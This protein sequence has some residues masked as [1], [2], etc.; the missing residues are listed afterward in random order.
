MPL[1]RVTMLP[2]NDC[3]SVGYDNRVCRVFLQ[4]SDPRPSHWGAS[5]RRLSSR[6]KVVLS[7]SLSW[8]DILVDAS[9]RKACSL[10][11]LL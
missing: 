10:P 6:A 3:V 4:T 1:K 7:A 8:I 2:G 11:R 5:L 9:V